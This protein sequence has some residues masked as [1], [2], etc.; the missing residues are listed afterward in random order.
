MH[1][2]AIVDIAT[3][4][5]QAKASNDALTED[6][7]KAVQTASSELYLATMFIHQSDHCQYG[8]FSKNLENSFTKWNDDY[9]NIIPYMLR[10]SSHQ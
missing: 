8:K 9:P 5:F 4:Q 3:K 6:Q 7:K 10:L 2:Q 1:Y